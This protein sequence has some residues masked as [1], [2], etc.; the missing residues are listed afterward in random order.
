M[1]RTFLATRTGPGGRGV[2]VGIVA[3]AIAVVGF[4]ATQAHAQPARPSCSVESHGMTQDYEIYG[5]NFQPGKT[6]VVGITP[7][8]APTF[9]GVP[10]ADSTGGWGQYWLPEQAGTY[11]ANVYTYQ[12]GTVGK[13]ITAC[14]TVVS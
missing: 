2:L 14:S 11:T 1:R 9:Y 12:S 3:A 6:Y 10:T 5:S 7:P 13:W 4:S 8:G